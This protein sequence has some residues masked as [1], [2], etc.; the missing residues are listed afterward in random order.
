MAIYLAATYGGLFVLA[1]IVAFGL[2]ARASEADDAMESWKR[3]R[4]L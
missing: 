1:L 3:E 4:R 2:G